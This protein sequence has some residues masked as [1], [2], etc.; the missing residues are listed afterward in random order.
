MQPSLFSLFSLL[1]VPRAGVVAGRLLRSRSPHT[2]P[3]T[4]AKDA[5]HL[6]WPH[7]RDLIE[8]ALAELDERELKLVAMSWRITLVRPTTDLLGVVIASL[9]PVQAAAESAGTS[10]GESAEQ[11][12]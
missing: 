12:R 1:T 3:L 7:R 9:P 4:F 5:D 8:R 6:P 11:V 10:G 2:A